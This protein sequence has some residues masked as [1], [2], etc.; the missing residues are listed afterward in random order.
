M[1]LPEGFKCHLEY[2][3]ELDELKGGMHKAMQEAE[4]KR[5]SL[6]SL[7]ENRPLN[8]VSCKTLSL[9]H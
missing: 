4:C 1:P 6:Q 2:Q 8:K 7:C 5:Q 9:A 3:R